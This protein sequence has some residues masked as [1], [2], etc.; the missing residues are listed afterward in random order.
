MIHDLSRGE[1]SARLG[2][3]VCIVGGGMAGIV[4]AL[5]LERQGAEVLLLEGG[6]KRPTA[7]QQELYRGTTSG[8]PAYPLTRSRF[9]GLG[10]SSWEWAGRLVPLDDADFRGRPDWAAAW[11]F[12]REELDPFLRRARAVFEPAG[13]AE[14]G[15]GAARSAVE[16]LAVPRLAPRWVDIRPVLFGRQFRNPLERSRHTTV[17]LGAQATRLNR[18]S[19]TSRLGSVEIATP[20]RQKLEAHAS[21]FVLAAGGIENPRLLLV[22][23][24]GGEQVGRYFMDH[25]FLDSAELRDFDFERL[26]PFTWDAESTGHGVLTLAEALVLSEGIG[27]CA[28]YLVPRYGYMEAGRYE[29]ASVVAA[30]EF[31]QAL[32]RPDWRLAVRRLGP[33]LPALP[34]TAS[35]LWRRRRERHRP[36]ER[37]IVRTAL[38]Q[39]PN[40]GNRVTLGGELDRFGVPLPHVHWQAVDADAT[41]FHRFH[42]VLEEELA[43]AGLG[44]LRRTFNGDGDGGGRRWRDLVQSGK[45]HMG[46]TRMSSDPELG[47]VDADCRVHDLENLFVAGSSVFPTYGW[48][49]PTLTL[50]ALALR[51]ADRL[52]AGKGLGS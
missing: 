30:R 11:P 12:G 34:A 32:R 27:N 42:E 22:S 28:A 50:L 10:G 7:E 23:G 45:H 14:A 41:S 13:D 37:L 33:A 15:R 36:P 43:G 21:A 18:A 1:P 25:A 49:N 40:P 4:L 31:R 47:V 44:A 8:L 35:M 26:R 3:D 46:A 17:L 6:G 38:E 51:L 39:A 20:D 19:R 16:D 52:A 9:R 29:A 48:A 2:A 24:L 5:E